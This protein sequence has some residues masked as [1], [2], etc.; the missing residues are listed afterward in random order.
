MKLFSTYHSFAFGSLPF[1]TD[2]LNLYERDIA[3]EHLIKSIA[4]MVVT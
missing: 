4:T 2:T 3:R 1:N